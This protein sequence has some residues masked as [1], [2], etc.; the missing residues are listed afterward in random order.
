MYT[1]VLHEYNFYQIN[2][3]HF[4]KFILYIQK[5]I[6]FDFCQ[7]SCENIA[8]TRSQ[9]TKLQVQAFTLNEKS[10]MQHIDTI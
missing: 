10:Y 1:I 5:C 8:L 3:L 2:M 9:G 7:F 6:S 4:R